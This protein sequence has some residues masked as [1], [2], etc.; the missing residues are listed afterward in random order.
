MSE[1][2]ERPPIPEYELKEFKTRVKLWLEYD[3]NIAKLSRAIKEQRD[4]KNKISDSVLEFMKKYDVKQL[5]TEDGR[6]KYQSS[7]VSVPVNKD[8]VHK[9]L[10]NMYKDE[11]KVNDMIEYLFGERDKVEKINLKRIQEKK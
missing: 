5:S 10:M 9:K 4:K 6:L 8:Y 2:P 7:F 11:N 1:R 3:D